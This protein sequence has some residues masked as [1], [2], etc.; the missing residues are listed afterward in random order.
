[1]LFDLQ[2]GLG[3]S[4]TREFVIKDQGLI[5]ATRKAPDPNKISGRP[6]KLDTD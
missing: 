2:L 3:T 4:S 6:D 1:M 5:Q